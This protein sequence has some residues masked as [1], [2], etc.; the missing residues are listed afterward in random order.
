M[1]PAQEK[2][3]SPLI[4]YWTELWFFDFCCDNGSSDGGDV[5]TGLTDQMVYQ[6]HV[7]GF[8]GLPVCGIW[9]NLQDL[10]FIPEYFLLEYSI[11]RGMF[12]IR[13]KNIIL[14]LYWA[15]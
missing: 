6:R 11:H 12:I 1:L 15:L 4:L 9:F 2:Q 10:R 13:Q 3:I 8:L 14:K 7:V 5:Q